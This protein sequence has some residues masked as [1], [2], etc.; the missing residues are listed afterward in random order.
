MN[1][2]V[3]EYLERLGLKNRIIEVL[4]STETVKLASEA[5]DCSISEVAK[6]LSFYV[7]NPILIVTSG[8]VKISNDKFRLVFGCKPSM[9]PKEEIENVIGYPYGGVCPFNPLSGVKVYLDISL[10]KNKYCYPACGISGT[11][12]KLTI[13]ELMAYTN[14][15]KWVDVTKYND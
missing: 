8:D 9:I 13:D 5:L 4:T 10:L 3:Y 15:I 12:I 6:T 11:A 7:P 14:F 2:R 1:N